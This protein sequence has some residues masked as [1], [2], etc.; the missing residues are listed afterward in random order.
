MN[1]VIAKGQY[2]HFRGGIMIRWA[3]FTGR[4]LRRINGRMLRLL[5]RAQ[6]R[7]GRARKATSRRFR[8]LAWH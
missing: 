4:P 8:K 6:M 7:Y 3:R 1:A 5:G 2:N